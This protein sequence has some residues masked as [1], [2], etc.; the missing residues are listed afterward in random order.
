M[1]EIEKGKTGDLVASMVE[2]GVPVGPVHSIES[3]LEDPQVQNN[4]MVFEAEHP[5]Y[6][7][8]R[9]AKPAARFSATPQAA[10]SP[11]PTLGEH[12]DEV[13]GELG[14]GAAVIAALRE[15]GVVV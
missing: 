1:G 14:C 9:Q 7:R 3:M 12:T 6:G 10:G 5:A 4:G 15:E 8:Y 2:E 11:P 13:L